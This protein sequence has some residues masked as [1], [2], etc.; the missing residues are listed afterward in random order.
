M[1]DIRVTMPEENPFAGF[2]RRAAAALIDTVIIFI[3]VFVLSLIWPG[4]GLM[5]ISTMQTENGFVTA[6][7]YS[8]SLL[9]TIILT[10]LNW[11]YKALQEGSGL[12]ATLGK[13]ALG[14]KVTDLRGGRIGLARA[15]YRAWP[16]WLPVVLGMVETLS[17][18]AV[19]IGF[20]ACLMVA[21]T[22]YK[23]GLHDM[24]AKCL[25]VKRAARFEQVP[26]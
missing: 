26:V 19:L 6:S 16:I 1:S 2:W 17:L 21:F 4:L 12:Q 13:R 24:M 23:Q 3:A 15:S 18:I 7:D 14:I 9:G 11:A 10:V 8:P 22:R 25:V 5:T 20:V